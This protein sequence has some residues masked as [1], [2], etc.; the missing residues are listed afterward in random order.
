VDLATT[1]GKQGDLG[2]NHSDFKHDQYSLHSNLWIFWLSV[3]VLPLKYICSIVQAR[4]KELHARIGRRE[5]ISYTP[6]RKQHCV[7]SIEVSR[8]PIRF[9]AAM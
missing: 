2:T 4:L 6:N 9:C 3:G 1:R 5:Y 7:V 8:R